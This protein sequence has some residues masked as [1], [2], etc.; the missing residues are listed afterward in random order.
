[1]DLQGIKLMLLSHRLMT[2]VLPHLKETF[3]VVSSVRGNYAYYFA[4]DSNPRDVRAYRVMRVCHNSDFS[5]LYELELLLHLILELVAYR[6]LKILLEY[7]EQQLSFQEID[8]GA[9]LK[10]LPVSLASK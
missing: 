10:I 6:L 7:Q 5:A 2:L 1:M 3:T 8:L 4:V 9:R